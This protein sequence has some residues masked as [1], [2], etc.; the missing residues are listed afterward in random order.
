[1][2]VAKMGKMRQAD[3]SVFLHLEKSTVS[4]NMKRL[5]KAELLIRIDSKQLAATE[6][7]KMLLES[8]I[9]AWENAKTEVN[10]RLQTEGQT[11]LN[12]ILNN[13]IK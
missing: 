11:A 1:M 9:P 6:K 3:L 8:L 2:I 5:L 7:G 4:R 13:L 12:L 10:E